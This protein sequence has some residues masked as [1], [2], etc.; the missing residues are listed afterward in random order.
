M[1]LIILMRKYLN[2]NY[3]RASPAT[4]YFDFKLA[5]T[6][7]T[8]MKLYK[9]SA[10]EQINYSRDRHFSIMGITVRGLHAT[11]DRCGSLYEAPHGCRLAHVLRTRDK[12]WNDDAGSRVNANN[13]SIHPTFV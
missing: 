10:M 13:G 12:V 8:C 7:Y 1:K 11:V 5:R 2:C 4:T 9:V 3:I 6:S